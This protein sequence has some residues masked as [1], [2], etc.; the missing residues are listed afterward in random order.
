[1]ENT[2]AAKKRKFNIVDLIFLLVII[3]AVAVVAV[4]FIS[5][6]QNKTKSAEYT[7]VLHSDDIPATALNSFK[8]GDEVLDDVG[9]VF[10][11]I[12]DIQT[13]EAIVYGVDSA[14][15]NV[16]GPKEGYVSVDI[17][18]NCSGTAND[19]YLTV[20]GIKYDSNASFTFICGQ[21]MLWLRIS[22][23]KPAA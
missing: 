19:H 20:S 16:A 13:A 5:N 17:T 3:A 22:D 14:G 10:G 23:I 9:K 1:M 6:A 18:V 7:V 21:S 11:R 12:T 15:R 8:N 4:K 2:N